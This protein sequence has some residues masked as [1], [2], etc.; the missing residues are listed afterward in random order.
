MLFL[1]T[2][3]TL[4]FRIYFSLWGD[5]LWYSNDSF[6]YVRQADAISAGGWITLLPNGYPLII[7]L[8]AFVF[9]TGRDLAL[10]LLNCV[11]WAAVA[12]IAFVVVQ[13][14]TGNEWWACLASLAVAAWPQHFIWSRSIATEVPTAFFLT[15]GM[16]LIWFGR[17]VSGSV[18]FGICFVIRPTL[19]PAAP[20][21]FFILLGRDRWKRS[22]V[23]VML[24]LLPLVF[25]SAYARTKTTD[26]RPS[27]LA[28]AL[29]LSYVHRSDRSQFRFQGE[30]TTEAA[31]IYVQRMV[32]DPVRYLKLRLHFLNEM[33]GPWP[34]RNQGRGGGPPLSKLKNALVGLQFPLFLLALY[35]LVSRRD[36]WG[37][38]LAVPAAA[39]AAVHVLLFAAPRYNLP[40]IPFTAALAA[41]GLFLLWA[42]YAFRLIPR[43][44][45]GI[46]LERRETTAGRIQTT[47]R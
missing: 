8:F 47:M 40:A 31:R 9:D 1:V 10:I 7:A 26:V 42:R 37:L 18:L 33:W 43:T 15:S 29:M 5:P 14:R 45:V 11:I 27:H 34:E 23:V 22:L 4:G 24:S 32:A 25:V 19:L 41:D 12:I 28:E 2:L 39:L 6:R 20:L 36:R 13:R 16:T 21:L 30:S 38:F 44:K 46:A 17:H 35:S 3:M